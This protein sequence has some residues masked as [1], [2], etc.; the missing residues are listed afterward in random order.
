MKKRRSNCLFG[1]PAS[2]SGATLPTYDDTGRQW[3]QCRLDLE[4][5]EPG[6]KISDTAV[7]KQVC[8]RSL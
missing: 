6:R 2:F 1:G 4:S 5:A 8:N 3:Q 7:A